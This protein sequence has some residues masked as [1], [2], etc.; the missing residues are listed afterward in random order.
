MH[1]NK[2]PC[3]DGMNLSFYP[4]FWAVIGKDV[5]NAILSFVNNYGVITRNNFTKNILIPKMKKP[6]LVSDLRPITLCIVIDCIVFKMLANRLNLAWRIVLLNHRVHL[7]LED[8]F[9]ITS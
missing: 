3:P 8:I 2:A 1:L 6:E 5:A 9:L 4:Y 7:S